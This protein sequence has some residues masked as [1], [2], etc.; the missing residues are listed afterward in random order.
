MKSISYYIVLLALFQ[1]T[2]T[3]AFMGSKFSPIRHLKPRAASLS[4]QVPSIFNPAVSR[5]TSLGSTIETDITYNNIA[6]Y[7]EALVRNDPIRKLLNQLP[8]AQAYIDESIADTVQRMNQLG[9]GE[10]LIVDR[11]GNLAGIFTERDVVTKLTEVSTISPDFIRFT[12]SS[13]VSCILI[14]LIYMQVQAQSSSTP[15]SEVMTPAS[16]LITVQDTDKIGF[17]RK[18]MVANKI[19]RLPVLDSNYKPLGIISISQIDSAIQ[20]QDIELESVKL[21]GTS[22]IRR[23]LEYIQCLSTA[24]VYRKHFGS[25]PRAVKS[26]SELRGVRKRRRIAIARHAADR[27]RSRWR[28]AWCVIITRLMGS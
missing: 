20:K 12:T 28:S 13:K 7:N 17:C 16:K 8:F 5:S 24:I 2:L 14:L 25:R 6:V 26:I 27:L 23:A 3:H 11:Q 4:N 18:L 10:A 22:P 19:R 1:V 15:V 21:Y 9:R